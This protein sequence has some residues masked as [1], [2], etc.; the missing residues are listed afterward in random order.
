MKADVASRLKASI[1]PWPGEGD[2]LN[3]ETRDDVSH[4]LRVIHGAV[5]VI[6]AA[7]NAVFLQGATEHQLKRRQVALEGF[8]AGVVEQHPDLAQADRLG[9]R[10]LGLLGGVQAVVGGTGGA[11]DGF[12]KVLVG[13]EVGQVVGDEIGKVIAV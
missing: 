1:L 9:G 8:G 4:V 11:A 6:H 2:P 3:A 13:G 10:D 7:G 12:A 5:V